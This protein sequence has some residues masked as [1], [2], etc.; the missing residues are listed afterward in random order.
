MLNHHCS[1]LVSGSHW[2]LELQLL[3]L[4]KLTV[5][6]PR[7]SAYTLQGCREKWMRQCMWK[8]TA[9][10]LE[11][12]EQLGN[13]F[14]VIQTFKYLFHVFL[15]AVPPCFL[16]LSS[17]RL[18]PPCLSPLWELLTTAYPSRVHGLSSINAFTLHVC[19]WSH[20]LTHTHAS[21]FSFCST[22]LYNLAL[23]EESRPAVTE[24]SALAFTG[25]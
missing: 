7:H 1:H 20:C 24:E 11:N 19:S 10:S 21:Q 9:Q 18:Q 14:S 4:P 25:S 15:L 3:K 23:R 16:S 6:Y 17:S 13:A 22:T 2:D 5:S 8:H 12:C